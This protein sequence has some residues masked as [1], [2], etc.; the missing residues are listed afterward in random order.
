MATY[1]SADYVA[2]IVATYS[3]LWAVGYAIGKAVAFTRAFKDAV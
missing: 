1:I 2:Y 3:G